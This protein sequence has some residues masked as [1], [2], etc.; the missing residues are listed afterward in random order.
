ML[1]MSVF[2]GGE[3]LGCFFIGYIIDTYG[4]KKTV[5]ANL[6]LITFTTILTFSFLGMWEFNVLAYLMCFIWGFQDS[7]I[8]THIQQILGFEFDD[9]V[10][11]FSVFY[12]F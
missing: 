5:I 1:A 4:S 12:L 9:D 10:V 11:P 8:N 7:C 3:V 2:G 6:I